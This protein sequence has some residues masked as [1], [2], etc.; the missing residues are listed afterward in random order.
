MRMRKKEMMKMMEF[1]ETMGFLME[2]HIC[3]VIVIPLTTAK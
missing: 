2:V 1:T 3:T